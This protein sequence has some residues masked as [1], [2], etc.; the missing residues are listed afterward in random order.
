MSPT[1]SARSMN[2]LKPYIDAAADV[3][4]RA[5]AEIRRESAIRDAEHRAKLA[6]L[7]ARIAAIKDGEPGQS[8]TIEDVRPVLQAMVD[9]LPPAPEGPP[10]RSVEQED[11]WPLISEA[12]LLLPKAKDGEPGPPGVMGP[13]GERGPIGKMPSVIPWTDGVHYE[14]AV[15][16]Y[17]GALF[18]ALRDTGR[19]PRS[20]DWLCLAERGE[21]GRGFHVCG[22]WSEGVVYQ[23][24]DVVALGGSSFA[25]KINKPG[26]C[27]G[28]DWQLLASKGTRGKEGQSGPKG[29]RGEPGKR[30]EPGVSVVSLDCSDEGVLTLTLSDGT[31]INC[32]L[33]PVLSQLQ[34]VN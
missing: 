13:R 23:A 26:A 6:E 11:L 2:D 1:S 24:L 8:V 19:E 14:D 32:D 9:D 5:L 12:V 7:D 18:Q 3:I 10:G 27:P 28:N 17:D 15:V 22:T 31:Q 21:D 4:G 16:S 25:A 30:G 29:E 20:D 34:G 33:Y